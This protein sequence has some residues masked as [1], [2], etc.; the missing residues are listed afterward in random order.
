MKQVKPRPKRSAG[1]AGKERKAPG[2]LK[3]AGK[4]REDL[5]TLVELLQINQ[6]ELEHQNEELRLAEEELEVSRNK[7]IDLFDFS[8]L[9]YF[10][11]DPKG[12]ITEVNVNGAA[13]VGVERRKLM[14]RSFHSFVM[15]DDKSI[16]HSFL[17][18]VFSR[19]EKS[20]CR[21]NMLNKDKRMFYVLMEGIAQEAVPGRE[22]RCQIALIDLTEFKKLE[23]AN[24]RLS[25]KLSS[26]TAG[27]K[28]L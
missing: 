19:P 22:R 21:L 1:T 15:P 13:M 24:E 16:L 9:P 28:A 17:T 2:T 6:I 20:S 23:D 25:S 12:L 18:T 3:K 7:Y 8:P 4:K 11:L 26:L 10:T 27:S 14:G 5:K